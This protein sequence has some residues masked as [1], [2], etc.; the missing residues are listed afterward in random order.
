MLETTKINTGRLLIFNFLI[1]ATI[2]VI[3]R[4][5]IVFNFP[6]L[7]QKNLLQAHSHFAFTGWASQSLL[8]IFLHHLQAAGLQK[9]TKLNLLVRLNLLLSYCMLI[10]FAATGYSIYSIIVATI[11]LLVFFLIAVESNKQLQTGILQISSKW[12]RAAF[13]FGI[14]S[15]AGTLSLSIMTATKNFEQHLYLSSVY[16]YLHFQY[17][18]YFLFMCLGFLSLF[19]Q[20]LKILIPGKT[21]PLL[22]FS[23]FITYGLSVLWLKLPLPAYILVIAATALQSIGII[24]LLNALHKQKFIQQLNSNLVKYLFRYVLAG[25]IIKYMLQAGSIIPAVSQFAFGFR[26]VVIAYLHLILLAIIS[27]LII[28]FLILSDFI[29]GNTKTK[30]A[31]IALSVGIFLNEAIL[32]LQG[33]GS[34]NYTVIPYAN[35][36]LLVAALLIWASGVYIFISQKGRE[37]AIK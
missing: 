27:I 29:K 18:G 4:Y 35:E 33:L 24:Y 16:W 12:F 37:P 25:I 11:N 9:I 10:F 5:K 28:C 20:K 23:T 7:D 2:G 36:A 26:S 6:F 15:F 31:I 3:M 22:F 34:V 17:N 8:I 30:K 13:L 14:L 32:C 19:A 1:V 21:F